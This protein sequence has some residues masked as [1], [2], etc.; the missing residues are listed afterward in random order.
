MRGRGRRSSRPEA[1]PTMAGAVSVEEPSGPVGPTGD[2]TVAAPTLKEH[3]GG[4]ELP[5]PDA[6]PRS[7][8]PSS[9]VEPPRGSRSARPSSE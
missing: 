8:R 2:P 3:A 9:E 7:V 6:S 1:Y 4:D 5:R